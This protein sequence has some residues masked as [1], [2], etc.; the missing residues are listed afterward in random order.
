APANA[1]PV[2]KSE[3]QAVGANARVSMKNG[4]PSQRST[5]APGALARGSA[6]AQNS[7]AAL[8][9]PP[10]RV[11]S[12]QDHGLKRDPY[13]TDA[14]SLD[15]T[16]DH[17]AV[18]VQDSQ[19]REL[20]YQEHEPIYDVGAG[21]VADQG[22][23][24]SQGSE[25]LYGDENHMIMPEDEQFLKDQ[26]L[27]EYP[28]EQKLEFLHNMRRKGLRTIEGDSYPPTTD[29]EPSELEGG[30]EPSSDYRH[31][32]VH[33]APS[34]QYPNIKYERAEPNGPY[35]TH[36]Q[37][38][39]MPVPQ[40]N[41]QNSSHILEHSARLREQQRMNAP[42]V[43]HVRQDFQHHNIVP[44]P[45]QP[46]TYSQANAG[47]AAF[48]M[49]PKPPRNTYS[50]ANHQQYS[51]RPQSGPSRVQFQSQYTKPVEPP[52]PPERAS[53][54]YAKSEQ[55]AYPMPFEQ[56]PLDELEGI[57]IEDYEPE[58]LFK[59]KYETLRNESFDTDPRA[60][61]AVLTEEDLQK[62]LVERLVLVQKNLE[63]DQQSEFFQSLPT[64]EW[65][66]A[67][68][69]FLDQFQSIIQRMKQAR[70]KKRKLAQGFEEE[71]EERYKHVAKK[72]L[73]VEQALDKMKAQGE[74]LV[75]RSP[76]PS[77][78]PRSKR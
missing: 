71:M 39:H 54:A 58:T 9:Y 63:A 43:Q 28:Y 31:G 22:I 33:N 26:G 11:Q 30:Q 13:D 1:Q 65:E 73:Q 77:K 50:Q 61:R 56:P 49:H 29:G 41:L 75:P 14:E 45:S 57:Q 35:A 6:N 4:L 36:Q 15:T 53:S 69:W 10:Q 48:P 42:S 3:R 7:S 46:P 18:Q 47:V 23:L 37:K 68:D 66:D 38:L 44:Q 27:H 5:P 40:Q 59:M 17:S 20:Q 76:K 21:G 70:Q 19:Q 74:S 72:Q 2:P 64:A 78:S 52:A 16:I 67:G 32:H 62:P 34:S 60:F 12:A 24:S 51:Q 55:T 8:Q 25:I